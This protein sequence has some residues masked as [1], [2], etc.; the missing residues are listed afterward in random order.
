M[1]EKSQGKHEVGMRVWQEV[2]PEL[3]GV[4]SEGNIKRNDATHNQSS[5]LTCN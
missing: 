4:N 2:D 1:H 5:G 3:N